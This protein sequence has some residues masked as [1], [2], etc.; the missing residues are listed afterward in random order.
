MGRWRRV[1]SGAAGGWSLTYDSMT[2]GFCSVCH[3][4]EDDKQCTSKWTS[5]FVC[6][7]YATYNHS[8]EV[9]RPRSLCIVCAALVE[10][11]IGL[12]RKLSTRTVD[13]YFSSMKRGRCRQLGRRFVYASRQQYQYGA[14]CVCGC[15]SHPRLICPR[16]C[17]VDK[18]AFY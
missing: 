3:G 16:V 7:F 18:G 15:S 13:W 12:Y 1:A 9:H 6:L 14:T 4:S 10:P 2:G 17:R 11:H 5:F 8:R